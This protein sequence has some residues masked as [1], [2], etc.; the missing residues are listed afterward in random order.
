MD[1]AIAATDGAQNSL[2]KGL[3][4]KGLLALATWLVAH[5]SPMR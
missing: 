2:V 4:T 3:Q 5:P 1:V